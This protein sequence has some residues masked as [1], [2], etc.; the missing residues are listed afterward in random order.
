MSAGGRRARNAN[1]PYSAPRDLRRSTPAG[2]IGDDRESERTSGPREGSGSAAIT[3]RRHGIINGVSRAFRVAA[4][5]FD[6]DD[7]LTTPGALDFDRIRRDLACPPGTPILEHI[8]GLPSTEQRTRASTRLNELELEAAERAQPNPHAEALVRRLQDAGLPL[9][10]LTRNSRASV[11]RALHNFPALQPADF[12]VIV[13]RDDHVPPKPA[14]DGVAYAAR[15]LGVDVRELLLVGDYI[16]DVLAGASAGALTVLLQPGDLLDAGYADVSAEGTPQSTT[17]PVLGKIYPDGT[18]DPAPDWVIRNLSDLPNLVRMGRPLPAGK[19]PAD[20]L[21][22]F[23]D[24]LPNDN[25]SVLLGPRLG[26]D[27]AALRVAPTGSYNSSEEPPTLAVGAD[28]VTFTTDDIGAW[29]VLVNANDIATCGALPRWFF[30]TLLLPTG[31]TPSQVLEILHSVREACAREGIALCGGHTEITDAVVRPVVSGTMLGTV[32]VDGLVDKRALREGDS[33]LLTKRVA[34]EGTTLLASELGDEL[35]RRGMTAEELSACHSLHD[36]L[37]V[38][39]D[40]AI[41]ASVPG[42]SAMHDVTE[43][44]LAAA[45]MELS[46]AG[47]HAI[48][49]NMEAI[50]LYAETQRISALLDIDPL[51]LIGS[52]SLLICC[53]PAARAAVANALS[54]A[55]IE[56]TVIGNVGAPLDH[57]DG[58]VTATHHGTPVPWPHF[59]VDEVARVLSTLPRG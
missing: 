11:E 47:R 21:E 10:I 5:L 29:A 16:F 42:V 46:A 7:T 15:R 59:D 20:L 3:I 56:S 32:S 36:K 17:R 50:P 30:A 38:V 24:S 14:G 26:R 35:Q 57:S 6:F 48:T 23:L 45:I 12:Q 9:G 19:F 37:S 2:P 51:G 52:G 53:R 58:V 54:T 33:L 31:S 43:G 55:G 18:L 40:A 25:P 39:A 49:V 13:S 44:G 28:P 4:V 27:V 41:A 8:A 34:V 1:P 22:T